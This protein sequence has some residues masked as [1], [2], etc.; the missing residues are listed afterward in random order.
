MK[1]RFEVGD[2]V[3]LMLGPDGD[4]DKGIILETK[5]LNNSLNIPEDYYCHVD[6][7]HCKIRFLTGEDRWVRA[8]WLNHLSKKTNNS[9]D[10]H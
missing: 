3:S 9:I 8:K 2:F 10:L 4:R 7:Y 5:L 6:E 1:Q